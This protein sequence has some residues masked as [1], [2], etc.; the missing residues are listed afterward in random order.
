[1]KSRRVF[2][3][4]LGVALIVSLSTAIFAAQYPTKPINFLIPFG[5]GG[6]ADVSGRAIAAAVEEILGQPVVPQNKP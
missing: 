4:V 2:K 1:M 3:L 6:A 5:I